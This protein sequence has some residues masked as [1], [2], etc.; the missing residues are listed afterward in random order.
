[1]LCGLEE[2]EGVF[3]MGTMVL[4]SLLFYPLVNLFAN[5]IGKKSLVI[6]SFALLAAI[7]LCIY[8]LG[9]FPFPEKTQMYLLVCM[10]SL[11]LATL[12]ILPPAILAEIAEKDARET[13]ENREGLFFA[14]KYFAVKL[15]QTLGIAL[16]AFLTL[17]GKDPSNDLGLRLNGICGFVLCMVAMGVFSRFRETR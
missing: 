4:V 15:G 1:V 9:K 16:F 13:G 11:P 12:G 6:F 2:K 14:V 3:L 7:F 17:Y 10:A 8:F 5:R